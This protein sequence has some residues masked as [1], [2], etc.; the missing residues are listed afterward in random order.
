MLIVLIAAAVKLSKVVLAFVILRAW[1]FEGDLCFACAGNWV[2]DVL[3]LQR[4]CPRQCRKC[5]LYDLTRLRASSAEGDMYSCGIMLAE[6]AIGQVSFA[7]P[8]N[9]NSGK[10]LQLTTRLAPAECV[11]FCAGVQQQFRDQT[12]VC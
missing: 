9:L 6:M 2:D 5:H 4:T 3:G 1:W 12:Q 8:R 11:E 10:L 7:G